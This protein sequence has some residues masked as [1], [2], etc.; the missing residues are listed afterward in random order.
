[1]VALA[2][3]HLAESNHEIADAIDGLTGAVRDG[4]IG[5]NIAGAISEL[6]TAVTS[7]AGQPTA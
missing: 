4:E 5:D 2:I 3:L 1:M 6:A 7:I